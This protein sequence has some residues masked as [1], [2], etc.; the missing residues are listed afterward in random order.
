MKS[1]FVLV[2]SLLILLWLFAPVIISEQGY[3][4]AANEIVPVNSNQSNP[5]PFNEVVPIN[6][7]QSNTQTLNEQERS[8]S[9]EAIK[10][11]KNYFLTLLPDGTRQNIKI[12]PPATKISI[13]SESGDTAVR[14][15]DGYQNYS[16][17]PGK[18]VEIF[19]DRDIP[20]EKFWGENLSENQ[21]RL[22]IEVYQQIQST[23]NTELLNS[24]IE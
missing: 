3:V 2:L 21:V 20:I 8:L 7:D 13:I 11:L 12:D 15:G 17:I 22:R 14:C 5:E 18:R 1:R 23:Q 24:S 6:S 10:P 9:K 4:L 16:C 19:Y